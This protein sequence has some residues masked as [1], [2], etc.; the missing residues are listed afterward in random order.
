MNRTEKKLFAIGDRLA[1]L[2]RE[3]NEVATELSE[4]DEIAAESAGDAVYYDEALDRVDGTSHT[5]RRSAV[6][7]YSDQARRR[8]T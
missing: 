8:T 4:L 2:A 6:R 3:R 5:L 7:T 1:E